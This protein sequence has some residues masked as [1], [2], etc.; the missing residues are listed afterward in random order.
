MVNK[1]NPKGKV[2]VRTY[3]LIFL[4]KKSHNFGAWPRRENHYLCTYFWPICT[5][6]S[7]LTTNVFFSSGGVCEVIS[8]F[9][10]KKLR[11]KQLRARLDPSLG[12]V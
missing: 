8:L 11:L 7:S 4:Q 10:K 12:T 2:I 3:T 1:V 9:F 5:N 6:D